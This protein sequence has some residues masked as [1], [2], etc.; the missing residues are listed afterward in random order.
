MYARNDSQDNA[1]QVR[2]GV[3]GKPIAY[4][5][6]PGSPSALS[7]K[8]HSDQGGGQTPQP[9]PHPVG[10]Q[11][12]KAALIVCYVQHGHDVRGVPLLS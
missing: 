8:T 1:L 4:V 12:S 9:T 6:P 5:S 2:V 11:A 7:G 3:D 10:A